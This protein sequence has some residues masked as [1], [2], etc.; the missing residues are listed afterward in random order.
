MMCSA[1]CANSSGRPRRLGATTETASPALTWSLAAAIMGVPKMPGA[2][3]STRIP[4]EPR[5][6][7]MGSVIAATA[8][9][10]APYATWPFWPS[11]AATEAQLMMTPRSPLASGV[12]LAICRDTRGRQRARRQ[13]S[14]RE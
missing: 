9:L 3:V 10:L 2:I 11:I 1:S 8:P 4:Y 6:R 5:S 13:Q 7:A 14:A 12:L